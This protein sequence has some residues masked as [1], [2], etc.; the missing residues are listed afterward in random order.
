MNEKTSLRST[1][2]ERLRVWTRMS[3]RTLSIDFC[4]H[5]YHRDV[6]LKTSLELHKFIINFS[7]Q[8]SI[9]TSLAHV[10]QIHK[11]ESLHANLFTNNRNSSF[12]TSTFPRRNASNLLSVYGRWR[13]V[14][15]RELTFFSTYD[16]FMLSSIRR[17]SEW[18]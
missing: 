11:K 7:K 18:S 13:D 3:L 9:I 17:D 8:S 2:T 6:F 15:G 16:D 4:W 14:N 10:P 5:F 12:P 1:W